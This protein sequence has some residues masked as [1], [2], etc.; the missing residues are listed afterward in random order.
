M[1]NQIKIVIPPNEAENK[2]QNLILEIKIREEKFG[3]ILDDQLLAIAKEI[4]ENRAKYDHVDHARAIMILAKYHMATLA[5]NRGKIK[6]YENKPVR[7]RCA[8]CG[9]PI[10]SKKSLETGLGSVCRKKAG[11]N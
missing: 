1:E 11:A 4:T 9:L 7:A 3:Y 6:E 5:Y 10:S 2:L 8:R